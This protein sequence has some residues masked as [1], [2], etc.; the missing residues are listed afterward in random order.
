MTNP[1]PQLARP[2]NCYTAAQIATAARIAKRN[3]LIALAG[4]DPADKIMVCGNLASVWSF[5]LLPNRLRET[6]ARLAGD[7]GL[8]VAD[9]LESAIKP[10]QSPVPLSEVSP[11]CLADAKKL[12]AALRPALQRIDSP[13]FAPADLVRLGLADYQRAFGYTVGERHWRRLV[14][15]TLMRDAGAD[16]F[17]RLEI[18]L[19]ENPARQ[20]APSQTPGPSKNLGL[21]AEFIATFA[22]PA[23]PSETDLAAL[24]ANIFDAYGAKDATKRDWKRQRRAIAKELHRLLPGIAATERALRVNLDRKLKRWLAAGQD[25]SALL[26]GRIQKRGIPAAPA[27]PQNDLDKII[28]HASANCGGRAAQAIRDLAHKG[29]RSGLSA[30]TL[31][32]ITRSHKSKSYVNRRLLD[33]VVSEIETVE[34]LF[35]G[36]RAQDD[37]KAHL[38]RDYSKLVS[39]EVVNADDFTFPVYFYVPDDQGWFTLT[40]GQCLIMLDVRSWRVIAWSLQPERNYNSLTIRT[41]MNRVCS[42]CGIPGTWYF[43]RGIW[44][45]SHVVKGTAPAG[46]NYAGSWG[47]L[48]TGWEKLGVKFK[49]AIRARTKPVE[50]VG[51]LLQ[52]QMHGIRGY[53]GRDERHDLP[54]QTK[55]AMDDVKYKRVSHPG[56]LF[57]SFDEWH[58]Q[59][60]AIIASYNATSQDGRVLQGLSPDEAFQTFWPHKDPPS[61]LDANSWHLVANYVRPVPVTTNG[62]SFRIGAKSYIYRNER[63]GQD[64]G[65]TVLA[66]FDPDC[67]ELICVTDKDRK[68]PYLVQR[69]NPVDFL[70]APGDRNFENEIAK[71]ASHSAYPR[72]RFNVLK[73]KFAPTYRRNMVDFE[74]AETAQ[75][76]T[77][78]R[79]NFIAGQKQAATETRTASKSFG[80]LGMTQP[81]QLRPGQAESAEKLAAILRDIEA[82]PAEGKSTPS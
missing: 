58:E 25:S 21:I 52:A 16:D 29:E 64:R 42:G 45:D 77:R 56:E 47:D 81:K 26:D 8:S 59:L 55:R 22:D 41:L 67:P 50:G 68:N 70:A 40:R 23:N 17:D 14:D 27:I 10:W 44:K 82:A 73:S 12:S 19:P 63:T 53:C 54:E 66:W 20:A 49:H 28:W 35:L 13:M 62:I 69:S 39:M 48:Q 78:Q 60:G 1:L 38:E 24:F 7:N 4:I 74:T 34:P 71:A 75:E 79:E 65:K 3:I 2:A 80:R 57:L 15:R 33:R 11:G 36:K 37:A 61:R 72:A 43:E 46:W 9:Y 51:R 76:M 31:D 6:I 18:Y 32:L 30:E 5:D